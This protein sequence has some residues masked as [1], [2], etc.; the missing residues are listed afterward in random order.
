[1]QLLQAWNTISQLCPTQASLAP[2]FPGILR[3]PYLLPHATWGFSFLLVLNCL[4]ELLLLQ[5]QD[6]RQLVQV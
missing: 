6:F 5:T 4:I 3:N 1:M 2:S